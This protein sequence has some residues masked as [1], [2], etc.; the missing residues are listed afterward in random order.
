MLK[1]GLRTGGLGSDARPFNDAMV[2]QLA[3]GDVWA[4][5]AFALEQGQIITSMLLAAMLVFAIEK[6]FLAAAVCSG[7][8][9]LLAWFG[10][11]HAWRFSTGDTVLNLGWGTGQPWA[12]AYLVITALILIARVLP[13]GSEDF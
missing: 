13:Q 3:S 11:L 12:I 5:G 8:A 2:T 10:V 7:S 1:A 9:S 4:A 6:R